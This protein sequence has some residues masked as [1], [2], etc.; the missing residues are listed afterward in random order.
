MKKKMG[1]LE[2]KG[3]YRK[4]D[5][6]VNETFHKSR[7]QKEIYGGVGKSCLITLWA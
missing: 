3:K 1:A 2:E 4:K 6:K 5:M 7:V